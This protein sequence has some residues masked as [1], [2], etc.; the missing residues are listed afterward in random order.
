VAAYLVHHLDLA[1]QW[2]WL[3]FL[4]VALFQCGI[5]LG[6]VL[7][8]AGGF[9]WLERKVSGRIQD[10]LGP[11]R[12]GG[13]FGW[14]QALADGVKLITKEDLVP[15]EADAMLF[16]LAPYISFCA[17]F[18]VYLALPFADGWVSQRLNTA[19]FFILA[20]AGLE[21]FGVI[22]GGYASGSKWSLFGAMR[23]AAQVVSY[24]VPLGLSAVVPVLVAGSMDLVTIGQM[25]QGWFTSW[26]I[27]HDPFTF[28]TFFVYLTCAVASVNRAPFDLAEA[29]SEL[30]A[31]FLTEYSGFRW[32]LFFM[33]E[34][35]SM[36]AVAGLAAIL[37]FGGWNG[38]LPITEWLGLN[39]ARG[40][41]AG[42]AG[43]LLGSLNFLFKAFVGVTVMMWL[44]WTLP[45]LRI[46][47][48]MTVCLKY[49]IPLSATMFVGVVV[50]TYLLPGGLL[51][52]P[53]L[54][55]VGERTMG[56]EGASLDSPGQRPG[57]RPTLLA[58]SPNGAQPRDA[59][60]A[61]APF[62]GSGVPKDTVSQGL[63]PGLSS[64]APS[65]LSAGES[66]GV[67][68]KVAG[69]L[70]VPSALTRSVRSTTVIDSPI[71]SVSNRARSGLKT[72]V[73]KPPAAS[74]ANVAQTVSGP[75]KEWSP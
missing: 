37:F 66:T 23:E 21:V 5:L 71:L 27:F 47:Q 40:P 8:A 20:V 74:S 52:H 43:D 6:I 61:R 54:G 3:A 1:P 41:A 49:C 10:R 42:W 12:A 9:T 46:D 28:L 36:T 58:A 18:A 60:V 17:S 57:Y 13:R 55:E 19:V 72:R 25:Q 32:S 7:T 67:A 31:G 68:R 59:N 15:A 24:E 2:Q 22:L 26:L 56:P 75:P 14:L 4:G 63:R 51:L 29:E 65:G 33:A 53:R 48:V 11:T 39:A 35:A 30:V 73:D 34:Y 69:T 16:R 62:Q 44:R 45:R 70:R 38:P 64:R 50:W